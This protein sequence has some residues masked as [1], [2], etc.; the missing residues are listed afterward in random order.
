MWTGLYNDLVCADQ[1][2][3]TVLFP[4]FRQSVEGLSSCSLH[5]FLHQSWFPMTVSLC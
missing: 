1:I 4:M 3:T 5:Q 2:L